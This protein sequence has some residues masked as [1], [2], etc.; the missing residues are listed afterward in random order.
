MTASARES[1]VG[2]VIQRSIDRVTEMVRMH[3]RSCHQNT[4]GPDG[5]IPSELH[6][7]AVALLMNDIATNLPAYGVIM[8][9]G[10]RLE[11]SEARRDLKM[12]AKCELLVAPPETT[13]TD[14]PE[15]DQGG[16]GG[17][18]YVDMGVLR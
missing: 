10:R 6:S 15:V 2:D 8:D 18:Q 1:G 5:T 7:T 9:E 17:E 3:I 11:V 4:L 12:V 13:S 16:Y 14:S